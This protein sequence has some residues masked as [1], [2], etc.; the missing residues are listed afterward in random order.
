MAGS[1]SS[2]DVPLS[3]IAVRANV[4]ARMSELDTKFN[5]LDMESIKITLE[6]ILLE[7]NCYFNEL[8]EYAEPNQEPIVPKV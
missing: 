5:E 2:L 8:G 3:E 1:A 6:D 7:V 4:R